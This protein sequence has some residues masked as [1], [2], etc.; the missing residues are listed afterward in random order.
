MRVSFK[1]KDYFSKQFIFTSRCILIRETNEL[2]HLKNLQKAFAE[3][4]LTERYDR[5][6]L[7]HNTLFTFILNSIRRQ[8]K[9]TENSSVKT[10]QTIKCMY[11]HWILMSGKE[12]FIYLPLFVLG[13]MALKRKLKRIRENKEHFA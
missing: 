6:F 1:S 3:I 10:Y 5:C 12:Q 7:H 13:V 9:K 8:D 4:L 2:R 11:S